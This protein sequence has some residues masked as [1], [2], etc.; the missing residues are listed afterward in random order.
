MNIA[1]STAIVFMALA[2]A[3]FPECAAAGSA[4]TL[5][6]CCRA[7]N[8]LYAALPA[9]LRRRAA[10]F[11]EPEAA[12]AAA[13][14][15]AGLLILA[16]GY[17]DRTTPLE[18]ALFR[19]ASRKGLRL[20][21]EYPARLPGFETG[22]PRRTEWERAV[23]ASGVFGSNLPA[24]S[25]LAVHDGRFVPVKAGDAHLVAARVAGFDR[26][27]FGLPETTFPLLFE[28]RPGLLVATTKLSQFVTARYAPAAAWTRIW[29]WILDRLDPGASGHRLEWR[30]VVAPS[31]GPD[32]KLPGA[33]ERKGLHRGM[34]WYFRA[35]MLVHP[36][37]SKIYDEDAAGWTDRVGPMP[38]EDRPSGDGSLGVLEGFN[39]AILHDGSQRVRWWRRNDCTGEV[40]GAM[41]VAG[42]AL[43]NRRWL[44]TAANL[45]DWL[46]G[47]AIMSQGKRADPADPA[48]GLIGW[49]D[50][51]RYWKDLDGYGVYYGDDNARSML[52]MMAAAAVL[53]TDRWDERLAR[54]LLA[55]LRL[56]SRLGFQPDR[57]DEAPLE[58]AGWR[59]YF[60]GD[61]MSLSP[62]YQGYLWA[63]FLRAYKSAGLPLFFE[64]ALAGIK[65]VMEGYPD[66]WT[67]PSD[68]Q[69]ARARMILPLAWLVRVDD[70]PEH[71]GWLRRVTEDMLRRQDK[72]GAIGQ[73][74][75]GPAMSEA[76]A[77]ASNEAY[78]TTEAP[79]IQTADDPCADLLYATNFAF[80]G[81]REAAAATGD[82]YY[83]EAE[84]RLADF[85]C[86]AQVRSPKRP[87]LD[88]AWF[89]AFDFRRWEYW[90]S[91]ADAGW[92]AWAIE[93]GWSQSWI[94]AVLA[95]RRLETSLWDV[96][97]AAEGLGKAIAAER[98]AMIPDE[99][100]R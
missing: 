66:R 72:S 13:P 22:E 85:L 83:R 64:R 34:D 92:G 57:I 89:R 96:T 53:K 94:A 12:V 11:I 75:P 3:G 30:P 80:L 5:V 63:C 62:H 49:N 37:W 99:L 46:Y 52:G 43:K 10:R 77:P 90:A 39:A 9:A 59:A 82:P 78:G 1:R 38:G 28:A 47:R 15:G 16:D 33:A 6:F 56:T 4:S 71:R 32:E 24:L 91:N 41:A 76:P 50:V 73:D 61:V 95:L 74:L 14:Q 51:A 70:T 58:K 81:L 100:L 55:N 88:G 21:V 87:E 18:E 48:F 42:R 35:R 44:T 86:R 84:D 20:F 17:P 67:G 68:M 19:E 60:D 25:I 29:E 79:L 45:G 54:C 93:S 69:M 27:V 40:A 7:D 98:P 23:V 31:F 8:D 65:S 26:A 36:T 97:A 2:A